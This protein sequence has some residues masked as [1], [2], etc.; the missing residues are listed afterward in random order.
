LRGLGD[1]PHLIGE[2]TA[3][4]R[5]H[6]NARAARL[7]RGAD[8]L[9]LEVD[10]GD[11]RDRRLRGDGRQRVGVLLTGAGHPHDVA[12]GGGQLGDLLQGRVDVVG[13]GG[14]HRLH[15][16]GRIAADRDRAES[17]LAGR[18]PRRDDGRRLL[19][20]RDPEA[21]R[22]HPSIMDA[23]TGPRGARFDTSTAP[24]RPPWRVAHRGGAPPSP[25][26]HP[27]APAVGTGQ[28]KNR[29]GETMSAWTTSR[30][31][32]RS[33]SATALVSGGMREVSTGRGS[34]RPRR[35][36]ICRR[37]PAT[38]ARATWPPSGGR[39]GRRLNTNSAM[40]SEASTEI[41]V[42]D[43]SRSSKPDCSAAAIS[44]ASRLT[45]TT[46][47]G[48]SGSR[49]EGPKAAWATSYSRT[50]R[51]RTTSAVPR[52]ACQA[53][54]GTTAGGCGTRS[55]VPATPRKPTCSVTGSPESSR[56]IP[57][58]SSRTGRAS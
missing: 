42:P 8:V 55:G 37:M 28:R 6:A 7:D 58:S 52:N 18:P 36:A 20:G 48:P 1:L 14:G 24:A 3:V 26:T 44:P 12:A 43:F 33:T 47:R 32:A 38:R 5:V 15:G 23:D 50:G 29:M 16:D 51:V 19:D 13:R 34:G 45:P 9:G 39:R 53:I 21:H 22:S 4:A 46:P 10:V 41:M 11:H 31:T 25:G 54:S 30:V 40:F 56:T 49:S 57:P 35:P 27:R 17:D 2:S